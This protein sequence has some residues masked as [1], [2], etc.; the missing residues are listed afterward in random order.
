MNWVNKHKLSSIKTIK[1]IDRLCYEISDL[2]H[3]LHLSFSIAQD[4][5]ID[6]EILEEIPWFAPYSWYLFLEVEF[7]SSIA[8]CNN[9][10]APGLNKLAWRH[11]KY[12]LKDNMYLKNVI[13]FMNAC[14]E[15]G[16]WPSHFKTSIIVVIPKPNKS[17]YDSPKSFR[18]IVILNILGKLIEKVIGDRLQFHFT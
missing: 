8:K 6:K 4:C 9:L 17:S 3:A 1:Y 14:I 2:Q 16:Y 18:P 13:N 15:F 12:I 7:T 10:F 11:L 5:C